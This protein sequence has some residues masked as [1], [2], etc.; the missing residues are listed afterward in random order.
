[1]VW[2]GLDALS[3]TALAAGAATVALAAWGL[4]IVV[5]ERDVSLLSD[6]ASAPASF[7][8]GV[9]LVVGYGAAFALR[10]PDFTHDLRRA[11]DVVLCALVG[12]M[13]PVAAF[14]TVGAALWISTGTWDLADVL[15]DLG[16]P[17][18]AY[19]FLA[20][21]FTGSVMTNLHSGAL[22][23]SDAVPRASFRP[24]LV[25]VAVVGT[26]LAALRFSQWMIPYL[27]AMAVAAPALILLLWLDA[28][29]AAGFWRGRP[30]RPAG[31]LP[32]PSRP[33]RTE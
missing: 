12:L 5:G 13:I 30:R 33:R 17:T 3:W 26:G 10:T 18:V 8:A 31:N 14:A 21:G 29:R 20:L 25:G 32:G 7:V 2:L 11:A 6:G 15:R 28:A 16:S 9:A 27:T 1:V 19:G 24:A 4:A 22:A 23:L